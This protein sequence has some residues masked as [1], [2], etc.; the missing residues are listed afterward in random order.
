MISLFGNRKLQTTLAGLSSGGR[1][2]HALLLEGPRGSG[3]KTAARLIA[4]YALCQ[5]EKVPC[6]QCGPCVKVEKGV[7]PDVLYYTVPPGKK[8]FPI[9]LV[10]EIRQDAYISPNE[11]KCKIYIIDNAHT[12]NTS[13]QNALLKILE[14]PPEFVRFLLLCENR[15]QM[16]PT[17]LSRV[18]SMEME[19]PSVEDCAKALAEL[20]PGKPPAEYQAAAAGA[21]GNIGAAMEKLGSAKPSK[22]AADAQKLRDKL[23]FDQRYQSLLI[24]KEYEKDREGFL[25]LMVLAKELFGK[26]AIARYTSD[27]NSPAKALSRL[28]PLQAVK[29]ADI[30]EETANYAQRNGNIPVLSAGLCEK[31]KGI[32]SA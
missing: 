3:K 6:F 1:L 14:E 17:I 13:A 18:T 28:T 11:G 26:L 15:S 19:I 24:L 27:P 4:Q 31:I 20:V 7:H 2:P 5:G 10:R 8:E 32:L 9:D 22:T 25:Q 12:M 29:I 21:G 23:L 16:L 30:I